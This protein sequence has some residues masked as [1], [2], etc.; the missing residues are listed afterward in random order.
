MTSCAFTLFPASSSGGANT[1]IAPL[2][3]AIATIPPPTPLFAGKPT[4]HAQVPDPSYSPASI[5]V[6]RMCGMSSA[7]ITRSPVAGLTPL[8]AS[9]APILANCVA[10][11]PTE[12]CFV[13]TSTDSKRI[14]ID[15]VILGQQIRQCFITCIR[16]RLRLVYLID[17]NQ[18]LTC[19]LAVEIKNLVPL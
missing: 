3:G 10:F 18:L 15:A 17:Q 2:P 16:S 4:F 8:F 9:V 13:Y 11:T 12:H 19:S 7:L 14:R 6:L 1:A 5:I